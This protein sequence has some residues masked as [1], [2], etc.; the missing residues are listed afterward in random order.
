MLKQQKKIEPT[1]TQNTEYKGGFSIAEQEIFVDLKDMHNHA[2]NNGWKPKNFIEWETKEVEE[3][4][5]YT[6]NDVG[7]V[8]QQIIDRANKN[9][10]VSMGNSNVKAA[11]PTV[12]QGETVSNAENISAPKGE[13]F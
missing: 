13:L 9:N 1:H 4:I 6:N 8:Y 11:A 2:I 12:S 10:A 5:N 7:D 3:Y